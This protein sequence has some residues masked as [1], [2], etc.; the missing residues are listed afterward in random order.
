MINKPNR[1]IAY[2]EQAVKHNPDMAM[3]YRNLGWGYYQT[4]KDLDQAIEAYEKAIAKDK[5]QPRFYDELDRLYEEK[6]SPIEKRYKLLTE[7]HEVVAEHNRPL[8][9][10][11]VA[12]VGMADFDR[13]IEIMTTN[14]FN[15]R[16]GSGG[17]HDL[18]VDAL[19]LR[20]Q[21]HLRA[22][23]WKLALADFEAADLYPEN[24]SIGRD[25]KSERRAQIFYFTGLAYEKMKNKK[26]AQVY[27]EKA[28]AITVKKAEYNYQKAMAY[29]KLGEEEKAAA[30][31]KIIA[32]KGDQM[33]KQ[34]AEVDF[35]SKFGGNN[36]EN[37]RKA[38]ANYLLG[39]AQ[40]GKGENEASIAFF[41][42]TIALHPGHAWATQMLAA[43]E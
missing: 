29:R 23:K 7:N 16:E 19:L 8:I 41:K 4:N 11:A 35:F 20:G 10:E 22:K 42:K 3:A 2:W 26:Q 25:E 5:M 33:L 37:L 39:L 1:A 40:L 21:T 27:Y 13:A 30:L 38:R 17:L 18:Y 12:A 36:F 34:S 31:L 24:Q 28:C 15:R 14:Y 9:R 6:G 32:E 43:L